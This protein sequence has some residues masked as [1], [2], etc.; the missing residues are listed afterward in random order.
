MML[1]AGLPL[2]ATS[3]GEIRR[4]LKDIIY[5]LKVRR[6]WRYLDP[7]TRGWLTMASSLECIKFKSRE[8][9]SV[10]IKI[11]KRVKSLLSPQR[12]LSEMGVRYAWRAWRIASSWGNRDA[13]SWKNDRAYQLYCGLTALQ[14]S[15][16]IPGIGHPE[17]STLRDVLSIKGFW[18]FMRCL[19]RVL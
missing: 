1:D 10:L 5:R 8:V 16:I 9:L 19:G 14:L 18:R 15:R 12:L 6:V 17:L 13:E 4:Q 7:A 2:K 3:A 11:L